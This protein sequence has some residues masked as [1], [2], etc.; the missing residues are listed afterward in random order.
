MKILVTG[1]KGQLGNSLS[2]TFDSLG[3]ECF[4]IPRTEL[5]IRDSKNVNAVVRKVKPNYIINTAAFTDVD[6]AESEAVECESVNSLGPRVLAEASL[7]HGCTLVQISTDYVFDGKAPPYSP[8][9]EPNPLQ[10]YGISKLIAEY[11]IKANLKQY[12]IIRVPV[13]Y[14]DSYEY[15]DETAV[16]TLGK[17][18]MNQIDTFTEDNVSIRRP[19]YIPDFCEFLVTSILTNKTG[20]HHYYN[21]VDKTTKYKMIKEISK[22]MNLRSNHI[23]PINSFADGGAN[24]PLDTELADSSVPPL[25]VSITKGIELCFE[26]FIH[27]DFSECPEEFL[28]IFDLDGTLIDSDTDHYYAYRLALSGWTDLSKE[29]YFNIINTKSIDYMLEDLKIPVDIR[30]IIKRNK[31]NIMNTSVDWIYGAEKF[32][33]FL[34]SLG[35]EM[36]IVTNTDK[37]NVEKFCNHLPTLRKIK[38]VITR[39]DYLVAKPDPE[40]YKLALERY[41][42]GKKYIVGFENT[43]NGLR[44]LKGVTNRTYCIANKYNYLYND[45]KK[46]DT[47]LIHNFDFFAHQ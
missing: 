31:Q 39:Q 26:R 6:R 8:L 27:P 19:V 25:A 42:K 9:S 41:G 4:S 15:L 36:A 18:V 21:S 37:A 7:E 24:R 40:C 22:Y 13:L 11:R 1:S 23:L 46:E 45:L 38:N 14:T 5:D 2:D 47:I 33:M 28:V 10:N 16:T 12:L 30:P 29:Y 20:I 35:I 43:V 44:A 17:K 32:I 3:I 34:D